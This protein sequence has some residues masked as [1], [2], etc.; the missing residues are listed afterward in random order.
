MKKLL[1]VISF[2]LLSQV[3]L[4]EN[5]SAN[6]HTNS[7]NTP[8]TS[9]SAPSVPQNPVVVDRSAKIFEYIS[10]CLA[11]RPVTSIPSSS[12]AAK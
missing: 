11:G 3:S 2:V 9:S 8:A 7:T 1:V 6:N 4:A 10:A 12:S 5:P